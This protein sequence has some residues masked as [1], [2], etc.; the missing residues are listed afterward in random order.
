M[1]LRGRLLIFA[2][3]AVGI[4]IVLSVLWT[5]L[6]AAPYNRA[7]VATTDPLSGA[8]IVLGE[9][10]EQADRD[11]LG[12]KE[13]NI[14]FTEPPEG[15][16]IHSFLEGSALHYGMLLV[17][18]LIAATPGLTWQRRLKFIPLAILIMFALHIITILIFA[19]ISPG[20]DASRNPFITLFVTMGTG[21]FPA[22]IW[23]A[24]SLRYW[25]PGTQE[26]AQAAR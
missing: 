20:T 1:S 24:L 25:L 17:I 12:L 11:R 2:S 8:E 26:R 14:Y 13:E 9:D 16:V 10:F 22:L 4:L 23:V 5:F 6:I 21:L 7:L 15:V 18:S 19:K 3:A